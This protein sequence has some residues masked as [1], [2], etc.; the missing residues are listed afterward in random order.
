MNPLLKELQKL[1]NYQF[2]DEAKLFQA[3]IHRSYLNEHKNSSLNSNERYEFLGDAV[4]EIWS[5]DALFKL[6]PTF[7]EGKMTNLRS[8]IV[9]TTNLHE[10]ANNLNLGKFIMLSHGEENHGG[11]TN[12]SISA[13]TLEAI[14]GAVYLDSDIKKTFIVLNNLFSN[15]LQKLSSKK[16]YKDPKSIFQEI[17]QAKKGITPHYKTISETGPDHQKKFQVAVFLDNEKIATGSGNSKQKAQEDASTR[18]T[19]ILSNLV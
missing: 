12:P 13:D 19:K 16:I 17:A 7:D 11:R 6:F 3:L 2:K 4:L 18:A 5:S 1:I 14:I 15:S 10:I 8:L 9:C